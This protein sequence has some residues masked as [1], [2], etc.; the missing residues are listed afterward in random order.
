MPD[1]TSNNFNKNN[2]TRNDDVFDKKSPT[3]LYG[4]NNNGRN[5]DKISSF[6]CYGFLI[7]QYLK[8]NKK[9]LK[10]KTKC[11]GLLIDNTVSKEE[12]LDLERTGNILSKLGKPKNYDANMMDVILSFPVTRYTNSMKEKGIPPVGN[13]FEISGRFPSQA[14]S[15]EHES[16]S[17]QLKDGEKENQRSDREESHERYDRFNIFKVTQNYLSY[18]KLKEIA[19]KIPDSSKTIINMANKITYDGIKGTG[20]NIIH[21]TIDNVKKGCNFIQRMIDQILED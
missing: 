8:E 11:N 14:L 21:H 18:D 4:K 7:T 13:G 9:G 1:R 10:Y 17:S 19:N 5:K 12:A 2:S 6:S 15:K 3:N 16:D 20:H